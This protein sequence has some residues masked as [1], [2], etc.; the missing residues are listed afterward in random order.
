MANAIDIPV[1]RRLKNAQ[2]YREVI[3]VLEA[4]GQ[5]MFGGDQDEVVV[6]PIRAY[7]RR[8]AGSSKISQIY[9]SARDVAGIQDLKGEVERI[10]F[11]GLFNSASFCLIEQRP[12]EIQGDHLG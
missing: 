8:L 2:R 1:A 5:A 6:L 9:L 7:Q 3:G 11:Y 12:T 10:A 4:K